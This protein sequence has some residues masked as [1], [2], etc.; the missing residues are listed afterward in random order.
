M[1]IAERAMVVSS[2]VIVLGFVGLYILG[3]MR[4]LEEKLLF[5]V[6][7][8]GVGFI[9]GYGVHNGFHRVIDET[10]ILDTTASGAFTVTPIPLVDVEGIL[11]AA[12]Y[13]YKDGELVPITAVVVP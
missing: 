10:M 3:R 1:S 6:V 9:L 11:K 13:A 12:C 7:C 2:A 4:L 8:V 5:P